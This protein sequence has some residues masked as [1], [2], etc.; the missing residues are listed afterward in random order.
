MIG[1]DIDVDIDIDICCL[2][3]NLRQTTLECG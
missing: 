3:Q 2:Q 1:F